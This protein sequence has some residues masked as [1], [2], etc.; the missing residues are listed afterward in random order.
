LETPKMA[1][2]ALS[3]HKLRTF[4]TTLGIL[5]GVTTI[6]TIFSIIQGLDDALADQLAFFGTRT[7]H[8]QEYPWITDR[9]WEEFKNRKNISFEEYGAIERSS[10]TAEML[11]PYLSTRTQTSYR[12][13]QISNASLNGSNQNKALMDDFTFEAGRFFNH[14]EVSNGQYV[15]VIGNEIANELFGQI[16]PLGRSIR[17]GTQKFR[18]IGVLEKRG[19][20]F[21]YNADIEVYIPYKPFQRMYGYRRSLTIQVMVKE[22][23]TIESAKDELTGILRRARRLDPREE[24][25]FAINEQESIMQLYRSLTGGLYSTAIG[26]ALLSLLVG[27]IGIMNIMLVSVRERTRE[28]GVRKALGAKKWQILLQF[29]TEAIVISCIGGVIG[30]CLGYTAGYIVAAVS[31]LPSSIS[32]FAVLLGVGFSTLVGI[33]FGYYPAR[34]GAELHPIEALRYE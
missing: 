3:K 2:I 11:T 27:G 31:P 34:K 13:R 32:G 24:N 1:F 8:I 19:E 28:I 17:I 26:V 9:N 33:F 14:L 29:L 20:I 15:C 18:V 25:D 12:N 23:Y 21:G 5:I 30:I 22:E 10:M 4:L 6:I 7:L 16:N